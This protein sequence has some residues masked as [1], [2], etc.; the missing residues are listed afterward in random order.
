MTVHQ[1]KNLFF[2]FTFYH[3]KGY[4]LKQ[5]YKYNNF[6]TGKQKDAMKSVVIEQEHKSQKNLLSKI[7]WS[8]LTML[9]ITLFLVS[10]LTV[11]FS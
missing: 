6:F 11:V 2:L 1:K 4:T 3:F 9:I 5:S 10:V 8:A 7:A